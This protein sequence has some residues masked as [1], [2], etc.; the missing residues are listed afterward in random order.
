M[1]EYILPTVSGS[2]IYQIRNL[3]DGKCYVG[4]AK[5]FRQRWLEH[6]SMLRRGKHH[7]PHLQRSWA[8]YGPDSFCFEVIEAC[9]IAELVAREQIYLDSMSP[10]YNVCRAAGSSL[11][12]IL[13]SDTKAKIS[14]AHLGRKQQ[15]RSSE[16]RQRI[17]VAHAGRQK[18]PE[19]M[20][21]FQAGRAIQ[22]YT[23]ERR[24]KVSSS[25][26]LSY[27]SGKRERKKSEAHK[28]A[29]GLAFAKLTDDQVR[30]IRKMKL[31]GATCKELAAQ[32]ASNAGTISEIC[33][34]KRYQ[35]VE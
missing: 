10:A 23:E 33:N 6:L 24:A 14:A 11:G 27:A 5:K 9:D 2:G 22:V 32:F 26:A 34:R 8:K 16:W 15:E 17:G 7:S 12:R 30:Q 25:L 21:A 3:N 29:I 19:H 4:S 31:E 35:W 1:A 13:S 28:F 20:A 18:S